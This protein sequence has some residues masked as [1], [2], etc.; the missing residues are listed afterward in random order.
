MTHTENHAYTYEG[1]EHCLWWDS[2]LGQCQEM[3]GSLPTEIP[4]LPAKI[5]FLLLGI[6][7]V[8]K[9]NEKD[10]IVDWTLCT[11]LVIIDMGSTNC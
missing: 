9:K 8:G 4:H 3:R 5:I 7:G 6:L 1:G 10:M 2:N 11:K